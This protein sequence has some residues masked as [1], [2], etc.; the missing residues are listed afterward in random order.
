MRK[1]YIGVAL[2]LMSILPMTAKTEK[3]EI[4][5]AV[6]KLSGIIE[7]P[8][9]KTGEKCPTVIL[10]HG[11]TGNK[12][13]EVEMGM[14]NAL[15]EVGIASVRFD[16]NGHGESGGEFQNM[17][18]VNEIEDAKKIY[19]YVK[20]L[21]FVGEI[22]VLGHSQGG[23]VASMLAGELGYGKLNC[24][25]LMA[26]AAVLRDDAIRGMTMGAMYDPLDPPEY[27][28][29]FGD[30]KLG[31][32]YIKTAFSLP[33]YETAAKYKGPACIVHGT[34]D[35]V[36]PYTYGERYHEIWKDSELHILDRLDHSFS[37]D[38]KQA[39]GVVTEYLV[40]HLKGDGK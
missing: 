8:D 31:R 35:R 15:N 9:L 17:T 14:V 28:T 32:D 38:L 4:D 37:Q 12:N 40:K 1:L 7:T 30:K 5:G 20:S 6:G 36:V 21:P 16:F 11:F 34:G 13:G 2:A 25:V 29:L 19:E 24:V 23:V 33:I 3:V 22:A 26:P 10:M 27:V 39:T 18:V